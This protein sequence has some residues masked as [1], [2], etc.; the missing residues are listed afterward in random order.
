MPETTFRYCPA[1]GA[2][3]ADAVIRGTPRPTC[4]ACGF[5]V[6]LD[7]KVVTVVVARHADRL[8][9]GRRNMEPGRGAWSFFGGYVDRGE[10]VEEA[11]LREVKEETN[12]DVRL[13]GLVGVYSTQGD[14]HI[15]I[16]YQASVPDEQLAVLAPDPEEVS[17]LALFELDAM[18]PLAF[19]I[20][21]RILR[22]WRALT[23][24]SL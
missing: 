18:P 14:P 8:L 17:E 21:E 12:L 16:V 7:P 10:Q 23:R 15:L 22:D 1:C 24:P 20:D 4:P 2:A 5:V 19:S 6:F 13:E 9:L 11:A 3:L